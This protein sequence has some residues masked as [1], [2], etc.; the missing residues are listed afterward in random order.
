MVPDDRTPAN[1]HLHVEPQATEQ[2]CVLCGRPDGGLTCILQRNEAYNKVRR[3]LRL[4]YGY[5]PPRVCT[6][7]AS[8]IPEDWAIRPLADPVDWVCAYVRETP[9]A[10]LMHLLPIGYDNLQRVRAYIPYRDPRLDALESDLSVAVDALVRIAGNQE[11]TAAP[12]AIA[13]RALA[14]IA[15]RLL[16]TM[17][18]D[19]AN[20]PP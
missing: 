8:L 17:L 13:A 2:P 6:V 20:T 15:N 12:E 1:G 11:P 14:T 19:E 16:G 10:D 5:L 4:N 3:F 9:D 18:L 7:L